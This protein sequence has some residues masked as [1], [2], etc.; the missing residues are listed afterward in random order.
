MEAGK[1][2]TGG[3][4]ARKEVKAAFQDSSGFMIERINFVEGEKRRREVL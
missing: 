4:S 3:F 1:L 2:V